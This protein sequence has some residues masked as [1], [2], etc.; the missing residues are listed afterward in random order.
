MSTVRRQSLWSG[1]FL[2]FSDKRRAYD[3]GFQAPSERTGT[4]AVD[5]TS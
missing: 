3:D 4:E 1:W 5:L 2:S